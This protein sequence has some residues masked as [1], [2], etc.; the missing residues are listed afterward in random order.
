MCKGP[1]VEVS[2]G[3][4]GT[5]KRPL[6]LELMNDGASSQTGGPWVWPWWGHGDMVWVFMKKE[7]GVFGG[8]GSGK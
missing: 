7:M 4:P 2:L 6:W 5:V 3:Y 1:G 8:T